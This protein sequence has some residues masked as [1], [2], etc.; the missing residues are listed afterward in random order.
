M[1]PPMIW[2]VRKGEPSQPV[3]PLD[4]NMR[5]IVDLTSDPH[6]DWNLFDTK[7]TQSWVFAPA[8]RLIQGHIRA[9]RN[10]PTFNP[11][12]ISGATAQSIKNGANIGVQRSD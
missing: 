2:E 4:L 8:F 12:K 1:E 10:T 5:P 9:S 11:A 6:E 7:L 3:V